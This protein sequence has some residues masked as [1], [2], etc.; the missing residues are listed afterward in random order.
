MP[1][2]IPDPKAPLVRIQ[3]VR[4]VQPP[5]LEEPTVVPSKAWAAYSGPNST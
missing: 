3:L 5:P 4:E 2:G 1:S